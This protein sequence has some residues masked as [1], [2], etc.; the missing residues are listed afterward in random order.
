MSECGGVWTWKRRKPP[1]RN[2]VRNIGPLAFRHVQ[3]TRRTWLQY[4]PTKLGYTVHVEDR[5]QT[6]VYFRSL[7][8]VARS[9]GCLISYTIF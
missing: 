1:R 3:V 4:L 5:L 9:P 8:L 7:V 2:S 6:H